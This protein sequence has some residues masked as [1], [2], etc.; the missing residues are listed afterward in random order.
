MVSDFK[1]Q[2]VKLY[3]TVAFVIKNLSNCNKPDSCQIVKICYKNLFFF[4]V[5]H[6]I[7]N[8]LLFHYCT[9]HKCHNFM[10]AV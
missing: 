3:L 1:N 2:I 9:V 7:L 4:K 8:R 10:Y 5:R 6:Y